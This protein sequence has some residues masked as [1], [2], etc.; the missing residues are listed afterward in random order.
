MAKGHGTYSRVVAWLK[1]LLP[2]IALIVLGTVFLITSDDGFDAGFT[3]SQADIETLEAGSFL[4]KPQIDGVT[5]RGEPFHLVA[6]LIAPVEGNLNLVKMTALSG[7]FVFSSSEWVRL[8]AATAVMDIKAQTL[9]FNEGGQVE[10]SDGTIA[11]VDFL[12]ATLSTGEME[13]RGIIALGPLGQ[14]SADNFQITAPEGKNRVL[15]FEN[16]VRM[17]Y[18]LQN[19]G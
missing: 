13:G 18:N 1:I 3:F 14:V 2:M 15:W 8:E 16:N 7:E 10:T 9:V 19:D 4:K 6:E 12:R 11:S 17:L 5:A